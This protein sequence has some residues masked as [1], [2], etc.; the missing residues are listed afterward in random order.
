MSFFR[1]EILSL[2][3]VLSVLLT[4]IWELDM[5]KIG[6]KIT[7]GIF[8]ASFQLVVVLYARSVT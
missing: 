6:V 8:M 7:L 4:V 2:T 1:L 5:R 3:L